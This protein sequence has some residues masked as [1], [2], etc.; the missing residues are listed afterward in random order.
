MDTEVNIRIRTRARLE[1]TTKKWV[2]TYDGNGGGNVP[3]SH[4]CNYV[5]GLCLDGVSGPNG[6]VVADSFLP[7]DGYQQ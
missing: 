3:L 1:T 7:A 5:T 6:F 4:F 2:M